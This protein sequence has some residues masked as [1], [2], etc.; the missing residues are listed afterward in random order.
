[1]LEAFF[2][3]LGGFWGVVITLAA[4]TFLLVADVVEDNARKTTA[5]LGTIGVIGAAIWLWHW[6]PL[7]FV[8]THP[9]YTFLIIPGWGVIGIAWAYFKFKIYSS[10]KAAFIEELKAEFLAD[11]VRYRDGERN[12]ETEAGKR[13]YHNYL[14]THKI[15]L[16]EQPNGDFLMKP[17]EQSIVYWASYWPFSFVSTLLRDGIYRT[18]RWVYRSY[19]AGL[20]KRASASAMKDLQKDLRLRSTPPVPVLPVRD[21]T[22]TEN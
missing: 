8:S 9:V 18:F 20:F 16:I 19:L 14:Q 7:P 5:T 11:G 12:L 15:E 21:R 22:G 10:E 2:L 3:V 13:N 6:N 17:P 4:I 1:M